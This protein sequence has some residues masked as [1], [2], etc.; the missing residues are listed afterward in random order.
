MSQDTP[1]PVPAQDP[2][3]P[4]EPVPPEPSSDAGPVK[5]AE[6]PDAESPHAEAEVAATPASGADAHPQPLPVADGADGD[7][8]L[9]PLPLGPPPLPPHPPRRRRGRRTTLLIASAAVLGVLAGAG[10]GYLVQYDREPTPLT[11]VAAERLTPAAG[12]GTEAPRLSLSQDGEAAYDGDLT[13]FLLPTPKGASEDERD[14]VSLYDY[15]LEY[16]RPGGAFTEFLDNDFRR[17]ARAYW[18]QDDDGNY[19]SITLAQ[20]RDE[21]APYAPSEV[22]SQTFYDDD[23]P[24]FGASADV[25]GTMDGKVWASAKPYHEDGGDE[26][27]G[28]GVARVGDIYVRLIVGSPKPVASATVMRLMTRQLE[29]L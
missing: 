24:G 1:A 17:A 14:W 18:T 4:H 9:P 26:Y 28:G 23:D 13:D 19:V 25:P 11:P 21:A 29:R 5:D 6:S 20:Y 27:Y 16:E 12:P 15:A 8:G 3:P 10:A 2:A 7:A 22:R